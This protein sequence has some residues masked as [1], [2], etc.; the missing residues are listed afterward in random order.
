MAQLLNI[1]TVMAL[2]IASLGLFGLAAFSAEQRIK[3]LGIR[4]VL[5]AKALHL[6][7]L[8][9]SEFTRLVIISLLIATPLAYY[10]VQTWVSDFAYRTPIS[11]WGFVLAGI[12]AL[13]ISWGTIGFQSLK[14]ARTNPIEALKND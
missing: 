10:L 2:I 5:G 1:F 13:V 3:E 9:S 8:F 14:S 11:I 7:I 12:S 4:K 6:V